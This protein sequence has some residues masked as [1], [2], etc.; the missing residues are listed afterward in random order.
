MELNGLSHSC[1]KKHF[2]IG[3]ELKPTSKDLISYPTGK[4]A[5]TGVLEA[6]FDNEVVLLMQMLFIVSYYLNKVSTAASLSSSDV[7]I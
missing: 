4:H 5:C 6:P 1:F 3:Q 7:E 2:L